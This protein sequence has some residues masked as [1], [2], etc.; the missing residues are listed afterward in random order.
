[1][2]IRPPFYLSNTVSPK[3]TKL[4]SETTL[5]TNGA[6]Y[7]HLDTHE[8][9]TQIDNPIFLYLQ[10]NE[11]V[12]GTI[13]FCQ[14]IFPNNECAFY[15][16][17]VAFDN[18]WSSTLGQ[19][20]STNDTLL[21]QQLNTF[22][23]KAFSGDFPQ[24]PSCLYAYIEPK[25]E[26]SIWM[27]TQFDFQEIARIETFYFSRFFPKKNNLFIELNE[28]QISNYTI[29]LNKIYKSH[30]FF[31]KQDQIKNQRVFGLM[32]NDNLL[33][34]CKAHVVN[35]EIKQLPGKY[36]KQ[37]VKMIPYIPFINR[38]IKPK[39]H[40]FIVIEGLINPSSSQQMLD[41]LLES[42]L[43][44]THSNLLL[45]WYDQKDKLIYDMI[46]NSK[47]GFAKLILPKQEVKLV[48]KSNSFTL[49]KPDTRKCFYVSAFDLI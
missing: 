15:I 18:R 46:K 19:K 22:F 40:T 33:I 24:T 13:A 26:R 23:T 5:G 25:N 36:G 11:K 37:L 38:L 14:R 9:I 42:I 47:N 30:S 34:A 10:R 3:I 8:R 45:F 29:E 44:Q 27:A 48:A 1:M 7:S 28:K 41:Q 43:A 49:K 12:L 2:E 39:K 17:Y 21:K 35:W 32:Q 31:T 4:L 20:R 16:R 6:K